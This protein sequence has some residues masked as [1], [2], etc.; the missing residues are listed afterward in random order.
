MTMVDRQLHGRTPRWGDRDLPSGMLVP[1][2]MVY[3]REEHAV[4]IP[5]DPVVAGP[6]W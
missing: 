4:H 3:P 5:G 2:A 1:G 6:D